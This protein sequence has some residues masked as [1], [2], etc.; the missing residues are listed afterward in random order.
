MLLKKIRRGTAQ[1]S[2]N[3]WEMASHSKQNDHVVIMQLF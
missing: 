3:Y 1:L 2:E